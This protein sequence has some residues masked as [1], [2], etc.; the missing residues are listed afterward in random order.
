MDTKEPRPER[1]LTDESLAGER[2]KTDDELAKRAAK[3]EENADAVVAEARRRADSVLSRARATADERLHRGDGS[4]SA[5]T[6]VDAERRVEDAVVGGERAVA[7]AQLDDERIDRRRAM[8]A[9]LELERKQTDVHLHD[10]RTRA[11]RAIAS[12]DD[13]LA[14]VSH[15][16]RNMLG[17]IVMSS[18]WLLELELEESKRS[19]VVREA[20]RIQRYTARMSRL[21]GDLLDI[22]SIE[23][24]RLAVAPRRHDAVDLLRETE[25]VFH[26]LAA[27][28]GISIRSEVRANSLLA[29]YDHDR[30][31]QVLANLVGNALKFTP[32]EGRI[33]LV[34][35]HI[36][37]N[38]RFC[39]ADTGRGMTDD[40]I[41]TIFE[42][43]W[44]TRSGEM[45]GFGLGLYISKCI[46]EAHGGKIWV[47]SNPGAGSAFYF[48]LPAAPAS[49][50]ATPESGR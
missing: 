46:V 7:D 17:G 6:A 29:R 22:V 32:R 23:A 11:D 19:A 45:T 41:R 1:A 43:F 4:E 5:R 24:G 13:F 20:E 10:E 47:E 50:A 25:N 48:T 2:D 16:L 33:D 37:D 39:V 35:E 9:L 3:F 36:G 12:R 42:K 44:Q 26:P 21:V 49:G 18:N 30:V 8:A 14:V 34:V 28:S 31:L 40:Q 27:A 38:I 15:D